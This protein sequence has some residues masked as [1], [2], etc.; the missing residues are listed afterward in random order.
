MDNEGNIVNTI[1]DTTMDAFFLVHQNVDGNYER[2]YVEDEEGNKLFKSISFIYGTFKKC[3]IKSKRKTTLFITT[4]S[5]SG[6]KLFT[7]FARNI[8]KE[9]GLVS[10]LDDKTYVLTQHDIRSVAAT[11]FAK[12]LDNKGATIDMVIHSHPRNTVPS[13]Y[14]EVGR[15]FGDRNGPVYFPSSHGIPIKYYVYLPKNDRYIQ[16]DANG[17]H[18]IR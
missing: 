6:M 14:N 18:L 5:S 8:D 10:T 15:V 3:T 4:S 11:S 2:E 12:E 9:F 16:Y 7:F 13:G 1:K 17:Y